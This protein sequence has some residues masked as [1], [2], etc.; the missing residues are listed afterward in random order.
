MQFGVVCLFTTVLHYFCI[1]M[2]ESTGVL[3]CPTKHSGSFTNALIYTHATNRVDVRNFHYQPLHLAFGFSLFAVFFLQPNCSNCVSVVVRASKSRMLLSL[4]ASKVSCFAHKMQRK[5]FQKWLMVFCKSKDVLCLNLHINLVSCQ[6][7]E[8]IVST[9]QRFV[10]TSNERYLLKHI[11]RAFC[12]SDV[13]CCKCDA[14]LNETEVPLML[15]FLK[16]VSQIFVQ[17]KVVCC[18]AETR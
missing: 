7:L 9:T 6:F 17:A 13:Q 2:Y 10:L 12:K 8:Q 15:Y 5:A 11:S 3:T 1:I 16:L 4:Y 14:L 18:Y